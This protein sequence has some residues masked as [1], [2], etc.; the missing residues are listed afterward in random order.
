[1]LFF[2]FFG[3]S[4]WFVS[5][6]YLLSFFLL[7]FTQSFFAALDPTVSFPCL[8]LLGV[9][10]WL[11]LLVY[12]LGSFLYLGHFISQ[13]LQVVLWSATRSRDKIKHFLLIVIL[14]L[15]GKVTKT[16]NWAKNIL[17][18]FWQTTVLIT[19]PSVTSLHCF[20]NNPDLLALKPR[21]PQ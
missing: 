11:S 8:C 15:T 20:F 5:P 21:L 6:A 16:E 19:C 3:V 9:F 10:S 4:S 18:H 12:F 1:M 2:L 13:H 17:A 14:R 7:S